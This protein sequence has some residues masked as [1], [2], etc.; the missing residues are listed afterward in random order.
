MT[1]RCNCPWGSRLRLVLAC[2]GFVFLWLPAPCQPI[3]FP[4]PNRRLLERGM[5]EQFFV[6]TVGKPWPSGNFGCVRSDGRQMHE[7]LDIRAVQ[8]DRRG[9]PT[10]P[11]Y[12]VADGIV[13]YVNRRAGLSNYGLYLIL[14]HRIDG[15]E[16]YSLYAHLS[17]IAPGLAQGRSVQTG[18]V[19]G[20]M[21]R[22]ANTS[23]GISR[24]RAHLHFELNFLV[25]EQFD[26]WHRSRLKGARNDHGTWNGQNLLAIDPV[27]ILKESAK[28]GVDY[29]LLDF[30]RD[31]TELFRVQVR[32][33]DFPWARRYPQLIHRQRQA[34]SPTAG[35]EIVFNFNG[36][37]FELIP[38]SASQLK[39]S[40]RV[41]LVRV[42]TQEHSRRP[43]R[44]LVRKAGK[45]WQL[46]DSGE[47]LLDLLLY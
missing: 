22:T 19:L 3:Q 10:D 35:Y 7:G 41:H 30:V 26:A 8:R 4:T 25:N 36:I 6:G 32:E 39:S 28:K 21:G 27:P 16:I 44:N 1:Q 13:A 38:L 15:L 46:S 14:K 9:E 12:A 43:C 37:P 47:R 34:K 24:D 2:L 31:Q 33:T 17:E 20:I 45:E 23:Q 40:S 5:E 18:Q 42:N 29:S 11:I